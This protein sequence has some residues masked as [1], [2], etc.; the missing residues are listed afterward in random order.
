MNGKLPGGALC[1]AASTYISSAIFDLISMTQ[2]HTSELS[3]TQ[4]NNYEQKY[5]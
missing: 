2:R 3:I 5:N 4:L 1:G